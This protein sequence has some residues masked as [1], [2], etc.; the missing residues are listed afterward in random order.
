[1]TVFAESFTNRR[2]VG[3]FALTALMMLISRQLAAADKIKYDG[4]NTFENGPRSI[5][6]SKCWACHGAD[7]SK[8]KAEL[9]LRSVTSVLKGGES[10]AAVVPAKP[11][12]SLLWTKIASGEMPPRGS[13]PLSDPEKAMLKAWIVDGAKSSANQAVGLPENSH[14]SD[15]W[16]FR[17]LKRPAV[18]EV[19]HTEQV[20]TPIDR[21]IL[22]RLEREGLSFAKQS[23]PQMLVRRLYLD[24]IGLL[25][26]PAQVDEFLNC[27]SDPD[28]YALLVD[29]LL[30]SS[31]YGERWG[32][33]WLDVVGYS[34]SNGYIRHDSPRP[35]AWRYR[36]YVIQSLNQDKPYDQFWVEQLAGD[37]LVDYVS[38]PQLSAEELD[39]L[40]ATH[41]LRNAPDGTDN[42]EG[43][44]ITRVMER[45][46]V[47]ESQLQ[48]TM[49]SM[50][51]VTIECARCHSHKFD[52]IPQQ[53]YYALQSIFYPAFNV[54]DWKQPKDR[55]I[56]A[57][58][59]TEIA[60]WKTQNKLLDSEIASIKAEFDIWAHSHRLSVPL[61]FDD[62]SACSLKGNWSDTAP[63]D[64]GPAGRTAVRV[65]HDLAPAAQ[66][67]D[68]Q[69]SVLA[70]ASGE[71]VWLVTKQAFDWTPD[72]VGSWVE[73]T[74]DLIDRRAADGQPA[75][76]IGYYIALHDYDDSQDSKNGSSAKGNILLDGNP[77]GGL[78]LVV[79]YPGDDRKS[80]GVLGKTGY[81]AG[82]NFGIRVTRM[83]SD[84]FQI[85]HMVDGRLEQPALSLN[86][87]Q[88]PDGG[89]GFELCCSRSFRVDN[90]RIERSMSEVEKSALSPEQARLE[91]EFGERQRKMIE[92]V[93]TLEQRRPRELERISLATDLS[94]VLPVVP[95]LKRGDYFQPGT[96][97]QPA[98]LSILVDQDNLMTIEP[99][100]SGSKTT[101]RRLAFA[102]WATKPHSRAAELLARVQ[103]DR[104]WRGHF[105]RGLV[106]T[107]ENF[108][109]SGEP[110]THPELL[111]WLASQLIQEG[112]RL[113]AIHRLIVMSQVYRQTSVTEEQEQVS[114]PQNRLYHH[115]C[116]RR[117]DAEMIR[118]AMLGAAG[119]LN[120]KQGGPAIEP[121]DLGNRQIVL[122][123]PE[124][125]GPHDVDRRSIYIR[126]RRSQPLTFLQVFDQ[127]S[128]E[129]NCVARSTATV[130]AQSLAQLN[131][132]F[133]V[134]MG[135]AFAE[136]VEKDAGINS[137]DRVRFAFRVGLAR[138]PDDSELLRSLEF[139]KL[140][141]QLRAQHSPR[142]ADLGALADFCR[143]MFVTN[144]F[145]QMQ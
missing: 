118:D 137:A 91:D 12:Q 69:L 50:F 75:D 35:L 73:A 123:T 5:L 80:V 29:R 42:T 48:I 28:A 136:R 138:E 90:V 126:H 67:R 20:A 145:I 33:Q 93:A 36:D 121:I 22:E 59:Q 87:E 18:P 21:L 139:L 64:D 102:R 100:S 47:L 112:W 108:G 30:D 40:V 99:P 115:F 72:N 27:Q 23:D 61:F 54:K 9:D 84:R 82:H 111:E 71:S 79:D 142:D 130:V 134:R 83:K 92:A 26:S 76:R 13:L 11:D 101:G 117:L 144:E 98:P 77:A 19:K 56:Y 2:I 31:H 86:A 116:A 106:P 105:G 17:R 32:R 52:P 143:M 49:S 109:A 135:R 104:L 124:G 110:P 88:L 44:E 74:F 51:G 128:P 7:R 39:R 15:I 133:A 96:A 1:M 65:D 103:V 89:F 127:G 129:P 81:E 63:G 68:G 16:S 70:A 3:R 97:V 37:E 132:E 66:I 140:Q 24:L 85:E 119:V 94:D 4:A 113:K 45:Y 120:L 10:G 34:D 41:F 141:S 131:G 58:G 62:F 78:A 107:P 57:A 95:L 53:D 122:A 114:D 55:W 14:E 125:P 46:A 38:A 6:E 25:P 43:N 60:A 8:R